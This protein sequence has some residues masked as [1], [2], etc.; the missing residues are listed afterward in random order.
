[1]V[2][3]YRTRSR[4]GARLVLVVLL[5]LGVT[6][7][8]SAAGP[9]EEPLPWR[10]G[11]RGGFTVDTAAFPDSSGTSLE[12]YVR[13]PNGTLAALMRDAQGLTRLRLTARLRGAYGGA[14]DQEQTQEFAIEPVDSTGGFGKVIGLRFPT[15]PGSHRLSVRVEDVLARRHGALAWVATA[16]RVEGEVSVPAPQ[17]ERDLSDIEF[18]WTEREGGRATVFKRN[19]RTLLPDPERLYGLFAPELR[20]AFV[21]RSGVERPWHWTARVFD[22]AGRAIAARESTAAEARVLQGGVAVD[23]STA[24]AGGYDLELRVWQEGDAAPLV[25]RARFSVAWQVDSWL[26]NP[27]EVQDDVHFLL[28]AD[29]E[30]AFALLS[31]GE[32][33]RDLEEF[34]A[35]RDPVPGTP[36]NEAR[37]TFLQRVDHAN[38]SYTRPGLGKGMFSDMGRA[39]I[40]Y[41]EPSEILHQV[42]PTGDQ[43]VDLI[44][45]QIVA[46]EDRPIGDVNAKG[47]GGDQ[48]PFELWVYEGPIGLPPDAD[49]GAA[50]RLRR[51]RLVFLFVDELGV[52]DYRLRYSTE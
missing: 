13:I 34:W 27:R 3:T 49:P 41:G 28:S 38:K 43:T 39:Y 33:E 29:A 2:K 44:I 14:G 23:L 1:M 16:A 11:G 22:G 31:P 48:R 50:G 47:P 21:A 46:N 25:R 35:V 9:D 17:G 18:L 8:S 5:A 6:G 51:K 30:E 15:R 26:R 32:Q 10:V 52:G 24:P 19:G 37:K 7:S 42:I 45:S 4:T 40:R 12:V 20:T 36:E